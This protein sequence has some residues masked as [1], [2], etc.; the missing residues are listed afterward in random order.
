MLRCD[1]TRLVPLWLLLLLLL[2]LLCW[3]DMPFGD[4]GPE[5]GLF[6]HGWNPLPT[7]ASA[8][9]GGDLFE[10]LLHWA[11]SIASGVPFKPGCSWK[12]N[13]TGERGKK[14][15]NL[16]WCARRCRAKAWKIHSHL[17]H[18]IRHHTE[19][20]KMIFLDIY[21]SNRRLGRFYRD[22]SMVS[23]IYVRAAR[24]GKREIY[25][26]FCASF[27]SLEKHNSCS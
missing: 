22:T 19:A 2:L 17:R 5:E 13:W 3:G 16:L 27:D 1:D 9:G 25:F 26:A 8:S 21:S 6:F 14:C 10:S 18:T 15:I 12:G 23:M 4:W 24:E 20:E 11:A 7:A